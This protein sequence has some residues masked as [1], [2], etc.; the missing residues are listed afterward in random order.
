MGKS[1]KK[2]DKKLYCWT[3]ICRPPN[4]HAHLLFAHDDTWG[5]GGRF[6]P[7]RNLIFIAAGMYPQFD[8]GKNHSFDKYDITFN[9]KHE[10]NDWV[11]GRGWTSAW[12]NKFA[13]A[14]A[15]TKKNGKTKIERKLR[16]NPELGEYS[17]HRY[18]VFNRSSGEMVLDGGADVQWMDFDNL[19]R[20]IAARGSSI[21]I[22]KDVKAAAQGKKKV[23]D[24]EELIRAAA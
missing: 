8:T 18:R 3:A 16:K 23:F 20:I 1:Q 24:L 2:Y 15:W 11:S 9:R 7:K 12:W 4:V 22:Y 5:G 19:G 21:E 14:V 6:V 17:L 10:F 13:I